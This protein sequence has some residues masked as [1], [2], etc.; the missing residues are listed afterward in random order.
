MPDPAERVQ[1]GP[2]G[3]T[4]TRLGLGLASLGGMFA[5]VTEADARATIDLDEFPQVTDQMWAGAGPNRRPS[6]LQAQT[7]ERC[8]D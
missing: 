4:V 6:A 2:S 3:L 7:P 8:T 5:P 1:L